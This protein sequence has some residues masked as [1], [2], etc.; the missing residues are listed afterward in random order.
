VD[1]GVHDRLMHLCRPVAA[2]LAALALTGCTASASAS[3]TPYLDRATVEGKTAQMLAA[4]RGEVPDSIS[5]PEDLQGRVG[6]TMRC[7][8]TADGHEYGV[9]VE[10]TEIK[11]R[12]VFFHVAVDDEPQRSV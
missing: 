10:V 3:R 5:C 6:V 1:S 8:L 12:Q 2:A 7:A 11:D 9:T 4:E